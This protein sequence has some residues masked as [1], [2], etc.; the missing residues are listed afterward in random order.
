M[1]VLHIIGDR[2]IGG[3]GRYL[4]TLVT[5]PAFRAFEVI[6]ACPEGPLA[7]EL[8]KAGVQ[9]LHFEGADL[10]FSIP[11]VFRLYRL[12]RMVRPDLVHTHASLAGRL[13]ARLSGVRALVYTKHG[14]ASSEEAFVQVRGRRRLANALASRLLSDRIIAISRAVEREL[15]AQGADPRRITVVYNGVDLDGP[16]TGVSVRPAGI[17][18]GDPLVGMVGRLSPEKGYRYFLEAAA[19]VRPRKPGARFVIVGGGPERG[20]I[21]DKVRELG[22]DGVLLMTGFRADVGEIM[23]ALDV[24]VLAS[25]AEGLGLVILEA[26]AAGKPVVATRVGGIPEA[27]EDGVTG[28]LV[29]PGDPGAMA[30]AIL[31]LAADRARAAEMGRAGRK[32]VEE[33]FSG[34]AMAEE[35]ARIY[36]EVL[37]RTP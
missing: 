12:I 14:L 16:A 1:K 17:P 9:V 31:A 11:L 18:E 19:L 33:K 20:E 24:L 30:G 28:L 10:S 26:M 36:R 25:T 23:G 29:P 32:R 22:L 5:Q 4:L 27:V 15:A 7:G 37:G 34:R 8:K 35:T 13:A 3:A 6:V 21:A 2:D